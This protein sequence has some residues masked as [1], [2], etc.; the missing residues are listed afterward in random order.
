MI[1]RLCCLTVGLALLAGCTNRPTLLP[2]P[3]PD[4]G[5]RT[6]AQ[7]S[8]DAVRLYPYPA[9]AE[10][11]GQVMGRAQVG[12]A[13]DVIE[14]VNLSKED[15]N[16]VV[17]WVNRAYVIQVPKMRPNRLVRLPF[18]MLY[19]DKGQHFPE[20]NRKVLVQQI[21]LFQNGK[22]YDVPVQLAD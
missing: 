19:N 5:K 14:I 17:V 21:E 13:L 10:R 3:D 7:L 8:A 9:D 22:L 11:G 20:D 12:Y 18:K 6:I 1:C 16:D 2:N 4:L 15:W